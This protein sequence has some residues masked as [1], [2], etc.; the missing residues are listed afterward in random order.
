MKRA[1]CH[2]ISEAPSFSLGK[3]L[4]GAATPKNLLAREPPQSRLEQLDSYVHVG[5]QHLGRTEHSRL[6]GTM[7]AYAA[8]AVYEPMLTI[9][10]ACTTATAAAR[11]WWQANLW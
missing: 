4:S 3:G 6:H 7:H 9:G 2:A 1:I 11:S 5:F 10:I 8:V